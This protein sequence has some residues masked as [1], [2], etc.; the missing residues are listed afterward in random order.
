[1][2]A[3]TVASSKTAS[4]K[5]KK[6]FILKSIILIIKNTSRVLLLLQGKVGLLHFIPLQLFTLG[7]LAQKIPEKEQ[8]PPMQTPTSYKTK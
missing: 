2:Q 6:L 8:K 4:S 5:K 7:G 1:M 3:S